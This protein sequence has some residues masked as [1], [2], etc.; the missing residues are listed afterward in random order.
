ME[1]SVY[2]TIII[3]F[4][5]QIGKNAGIFNVTTWTTKISNGFPEIAEKQIPSLHLWF[6]K[7]LATVVFGI[8]EKL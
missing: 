3:V 4:S 8:G 7:T 5:F 2:T 1:N 6:N